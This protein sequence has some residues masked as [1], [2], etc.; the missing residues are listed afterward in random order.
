[1][2]KIGDEERSKKSNTYISTQVS[3]ALFFA[4][5]LE[6]AAATQRRACFGDV[7]QDL[8][9]EKTRMAI[10]DGVWWKGF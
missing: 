6:T 10:D 1:M 5:I 7:T 4:E 3:P 2:Q 8:D 9:E